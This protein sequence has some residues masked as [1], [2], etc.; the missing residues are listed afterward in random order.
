MADSFIV[1]IN[2]D[3]LRQNFCMAEAK[4]WTEDEVKEWLRESG[5]IERPDGWLCEEISL[6]LL[7]R[8]EILSVQDF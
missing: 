7:D 5:F 8:T 3:R 2:L 4:L 6:G 1:R